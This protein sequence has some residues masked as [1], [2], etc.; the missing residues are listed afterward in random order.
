MKTGP[1]GTCPQIRSPVLGNPSI[2]ASDESLRTTMPRA[3]VAAANRGSN[4]STRES[5]ASAVTCTTRCS[6]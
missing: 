4:S 3:P 2:R 6:P 5:M 1:S